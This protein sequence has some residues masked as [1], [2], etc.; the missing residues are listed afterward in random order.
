MAL[1]PA[2]RR[3]KREAEAAG[4]KISG[5]RGLDRPTAPD[6]HL[7][8]GTLNSKH[9][10]KMGFSN[11]DG[12]EKPKEFVSDDLDPFTGQRGVTEWVCR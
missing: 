7:V 6:P 3:R 8:C 11:H 1:T 10:P 5:D 2:T 9:C 12:G 4:L